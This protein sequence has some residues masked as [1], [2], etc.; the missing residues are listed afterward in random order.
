MIT[1]E[2]VTFGIIHLVVPLI[3]LFFFFRL[4]WNMKKEKIQNPPVIELLSIFVTYG[5]LIMVVL[6]TLFWQWSGAA[7]LGMFYLVLGAPIVMG[8]IAYGLYRIKEESKYHKWIYNLA[9]LYYA[10]A[11]ITILILFAI[12]KH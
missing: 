1:R 5:G 9:L 11:P 3:G 7:S 6:T 8:A 12:D 2:I 4:K 10:I